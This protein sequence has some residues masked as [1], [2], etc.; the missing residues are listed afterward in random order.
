MFHISFVC[1]SSSSSYFIPSGV[2]LWQ[3]GNFSFQNP[4]MI[5]FPGL[6]SK[7]WWW[8]NIFGGCLIWQTYCH[9]CSVSLLWVFS[10]I[11]Q[12]TNILRISF[13]E[14]CESVKTTRIKSFLQFLRKGFFFKLSYDNLY[15]QLSHSD[16]VGKHKVN[17]YHTMLILLIC[18]QMETW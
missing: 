13:L 5:T 15:A 4:Y 10:E 18:S 9:F 2:K 16:Y 7:N 14:T 11:S 12:F 17:N 3:V 1:L 8:L 6:F